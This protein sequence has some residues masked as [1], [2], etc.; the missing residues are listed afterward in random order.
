M[1]RSS[2]RSIVSVLSSSPCSVNTASGV[3]VAT[4]VSVYENT[5]SV[6]VSRAELLIVSA[7]PDIRMRALTESESK[8]VLLKAR[9]RT[10]ESDA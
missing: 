6:F 8:S 9:S 4:G 2:E 7:S 1:K 3:M 5:V 10:T